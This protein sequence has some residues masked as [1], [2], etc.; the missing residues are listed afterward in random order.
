MTVDPT[1]ITWEEPPTTR[2][3]NPYVI[4]YRDALEANPG[5]SARIAEFNGEDAEKKASGTAQ[6]FTRLEGFTASYKKVPGTDDTYRVWAQ[7]DAPGTEPDE[8]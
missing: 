8:D 7:Y 4:D 5:K 2:S 3:K 1:E 6:A